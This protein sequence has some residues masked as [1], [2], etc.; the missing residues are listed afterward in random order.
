MHAP[1]RATPLVKEGKAEANSLT[2]LMS[3]QEKLPALDRKKEEKE[4]KETKTL[5][6][7]N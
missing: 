4:N 5:N 6:L 2:K 1:V 3:L 7:H